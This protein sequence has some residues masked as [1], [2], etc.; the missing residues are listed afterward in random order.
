MYKF[1]ICIW[2]ASLVLNVA[3]SL[4]SVY[5]ILSLKGHS[6]DVGT[7]ISSSVFLM[8]LSVSKKTIDET[9]NLSKEAPK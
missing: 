3:V 9:K 5:S 2:W 4:L 7:L 1:V 6:G 8:M